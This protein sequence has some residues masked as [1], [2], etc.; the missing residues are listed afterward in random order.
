MCIISLV[1]VISTPGLTSIH[2]HHTLRLSIFHLTCGLMKSN[3]CYGYI[4]ETP[5]QVSHPTGHSGSMFIKPGEG[6]KGF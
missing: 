1:H 2:H 3:I 4:K 5:Q 6:V